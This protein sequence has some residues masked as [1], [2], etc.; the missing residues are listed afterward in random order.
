MFVTNCYGLNTIKIITVVE[1]K[2]RKCEEGLSVRVKL[3]L[4]YKN[5]KLPNQINTSSGQYNVIVI[6]LPQR[7]NIAIFISLKHF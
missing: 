6:L 4:K 5:I 3:N 2:M 7:P 1:E